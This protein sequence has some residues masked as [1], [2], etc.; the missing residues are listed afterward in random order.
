MIA[1]NQILM[2]TFCTILFAVPNS[3]LFGFLVSV[4]DSTVV[5]LLQ[6]AFVKMQTLKL[7]NMEN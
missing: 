2:Y 4:R 7:D 3:S 6:L 5:S 1:I